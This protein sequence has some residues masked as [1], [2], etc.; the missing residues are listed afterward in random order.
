MVNEDVL[1]IFNWKRILLAVS[2]G[3][4]GASYLL[5]SNFDISAFENVN[6]NY[7]SYFWLGIALLMMAIRDL[8][9]MYRI[10]VLTDY[11]ISWR[12]SFDVIMLW[13]FASALTPSVVGGS[14]VALFIVHKEGISL[15]K[16]TAVVMVTALLD[17]LFYIL[18]VPLVIVMVG[19]SNLFPVSLEKEIFGFNVGTTGLFILGYLFILMLTGIIA[20]AIFVNPRGF[21]SILLSIFRLK[22]IRKWRYQAIGIGNDIMITSKALKGKSQMFWIRAITATFFSWTARYWVVNFMLLA[23][24]DVGDHLVIYGRQLVMWVIMLISP[25]PGSSGVA[26][27]AFS[28]FLGEFTLGLAA[29]FSLLWRLISYYPY[30]FIGAVVLPNWIKRVYAAK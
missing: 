3:L 19:F 27:L 2:I 14:G 4:S 5:W 29:M 28:G 25:T 12:N 15:G 17:E 16:S 10:R 20:Y 11:R 8:A 1:K 7:Q 21:K 30:L 18:M 9:Y 6:W 26:E 23:F 13:E 24:L 22:L